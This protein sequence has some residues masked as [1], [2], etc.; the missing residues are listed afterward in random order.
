MQKKLAASVRSIS[1]KRVRLDLD[2]LEALGLTIE[3]LKEAITKRDIKNYIG[4]GVIKILPAYGTSKSRIRKNLIQRRKGKQR[5][6]GR[7]KGKMTAR[8]P[9]KAE[10][11]RDI[12]KQ[13]AFIKLLRVKSIIENDVY[14]NLYMKVKGGFFR[15][16]NHI[17][18]YIKEHGLVRNDTK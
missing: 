16:K 8:N 5:G 14:K 1:T 11:I 18:I 12:R 10:W 6:F 7:R 4:N 3:N 9:R 13:R 17:K 2:R 15:N